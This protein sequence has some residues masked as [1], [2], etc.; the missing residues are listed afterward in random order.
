MNQHSPAHPA[1]PCGICEKPFEARRKYVVCTLCRSNIHIKCN[2]IEYTTFN[3]MKKK[4]ISMCKKCNQ[5]FPFSE[6]RDLDRNSDQEHSAS[7]DMRL[8]FRS[9]NDFNQQHNPSKKD[10]QES[11]PIIDCKYIDTKQS[12]LTAKHSTSYVST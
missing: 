11:E 4:E 5:H 7:E 1:N 6:V 10:T 9:L 2:D 3:K 12:N 8:F